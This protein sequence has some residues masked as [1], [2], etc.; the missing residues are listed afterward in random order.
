M[1]VA[2]WDQLFGTSTFSCRKITCP[3]S[4]PM[5]AVRRSHSTLSNGAVLPS[6]NQ[7]G[8]S[9]PVAFRVV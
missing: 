1:F 2:V 9:S 4:F 6:V 8:K 5:T 3:L 7:R